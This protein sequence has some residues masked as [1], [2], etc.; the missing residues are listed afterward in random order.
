MPVV[1]VMVRQLVPEPKLDGPLL[2]EPPKAVSVIFAVTLSVLD[3]VTDC[4]PEHG[5]EI[6]SPLQATWFG[7]LIA[8]FTADSLSE[9]AV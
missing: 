7:P 1:A 9:D 8:E 6:V 4:A 5:I 3:H 2:G